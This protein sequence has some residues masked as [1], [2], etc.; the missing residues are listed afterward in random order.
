MLKR[1]SPF[2]LTYHFKNI[3]K[4]MVPS[5]EE[6]EEEEEEPPTADRGK[7]R[8]GD[9]WRRSGDPTERERNFPR[10]RVAHITNTA[11]T[12]SVRY[13]STSLP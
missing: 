1:N 13:A 10:C 3:I 6:E 4:F 12:T 5:G 7:G 2:G 11:W 8:F 9:G